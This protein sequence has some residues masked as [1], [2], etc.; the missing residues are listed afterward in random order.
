MQRRLVAGVEVHLTEHDGLTGRLSVL[1]QDVVR[2]GLRADC[3]QLRFDTAC[4]A[5]QLSERLMR[6]MRSTPSGSLTRSV[7]LNRLPVVAS[8]VSFFVNSVFLPVSLLITTHVIV[9]AV[10]SD[11]GTSNTLNNSSNRECSTRTG[12][13]LHGLRYLRTASY[14]PAIFASVRFGSESR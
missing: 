3:R 10:V 5:G 9:G 13:L 14:A 4:D 1:R 7:T 11:F 6:W 8:N 2:N 12:P